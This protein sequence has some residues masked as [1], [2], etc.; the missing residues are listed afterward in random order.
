MDIDLENLLFTEAA[1]TPKEALKSGIAAIG[2]NRA[3]TDGFVVLVSYDRMVK[4]INNSADFSFDLSNRAI[5]G[6][7]GFTDE[8]FEDLYKVERSAG[9]NKY[10]VLTYQT[11]MYTLRENG[12]WLHSDFSL[13]NDSWRVWQKMFELSDK[14]GANVYKAKWLGDWNP[15]LI[16][17]GVDIAREHLKDRA[18]ERAAFKVMNNDLTSEEEVTA[19]LGKFAPM[20]GN[21]WAYQLKKPM[22]QVSAMFDKGKE[23]MALARKKGYTFN[24]IYQAGENF[25]DRVY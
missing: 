18:F 7:V 6:Y 3:G 25:F 8:G 19:A 13:S 2:Q 11:V 15:E 4:T 5:V 16:G 21:L 1:P 10:G 20:C 17:S 9:V 24:D 12:G 22:S 14:N 23:L